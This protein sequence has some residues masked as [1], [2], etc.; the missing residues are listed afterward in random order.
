MLVIAAGRTLLLRDRRMGTHLWVVLT[1]PDP[2]LKVVIVAL[3]S[4]RA[5]TDKTVQLNVGDH[6]FVRRSTNVDFSTATYAPVSKLSTGLATGRATLDS[7]MSPAALAAIQQ[8]LLVSSRTPND[9]VSY[10]R[11]IFGS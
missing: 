5:H 2:M 4:A 10:C 6:P 1:D 11:P 8:G 7:D 3:V 9:I